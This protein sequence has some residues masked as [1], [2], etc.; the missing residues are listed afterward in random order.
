MADLRESGSI[1]QDADIIIF[2]YNPAEKDQ[3]ESNRNHV[4]FDIAKNRSGVTSN[5]ALLFNKNMSKFNNVKI[6]R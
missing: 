3:D 5:F 1:E 2:L 6:A 4:N